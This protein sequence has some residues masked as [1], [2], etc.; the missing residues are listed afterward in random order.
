V[1]DERTAS[2]FEKAR[3]TTPRFQI[4]A[5]DI[6]DLYWH[7]IGC[8]VS[9][10]HLPELCER[11]LIGRGMANSMLSAAQLIHE[12]DTLW[13]LSPSRITARLRNVP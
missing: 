1:L 4:E 3:T 12:P 6:A 13:E 10:E 9:L 7:L 8:V 2:L 11:L 5:F